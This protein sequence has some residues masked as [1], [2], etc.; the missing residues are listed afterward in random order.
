[1]KELDLETI[2]KLVRKNGGYPNPDMDTILESLDLSRWDFFSEIDK[3]YG[4]KNWLD[5]N[6][7]KMNQ[8]NGGKGVK[9]NLP[10]WGSDNYINILVD[11]FDYEF[12]Q[13]YSRIYLEDFKITDSLLDSP[14]GKVSYDRLLEI[15]LDDDPYEVENFKDDFRSYVTNGLSE[16]LGIIIS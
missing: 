2:L 6:I 14:Y 5:S 11:S 15:I 1:M 12:H 9:I 13:N 10:R 4:I 16:Q 8:L 3:E 7:P